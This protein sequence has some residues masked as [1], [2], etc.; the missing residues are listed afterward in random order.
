MRPHAERPGAAHRRTGSG[1]RQSAAHGHA[2]RGGH[3]RERQ[4]DDNRRPDHVRTRH[5]R[6][7]PACSWPPITAATLAI[8]G[9]LRP[10]QRHRSARRLSRPPA[11][12]AGRPFMLAVA[13]LVN[14]H[15]HC[16][17]GTSA[18]TGTPP[19]A[20]PGRRAPPD[21]SPT[22][23]FEHDFIGVY[24]N[25]STK[26]EGHHTTL[27][28]QLAVRHRPAHAARRT[29][30]SNTTSSDY[31]GRHGII[32]SDHVTAGSS[33]YNTTEGNGLNGI[34]MDE[35][36]TGN[37]IADNTVAGQQVRRRGDGQLQQQY[38]LR[39]TPYTATGSGSPCAAAPRDRRC[40]QHGD[41]QQN[42]RPGRGPGREHV[43]RQRRRSGRQAASA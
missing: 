4:L 31:N 5:D 14:D 33:A 42:G 38:A 2:E 36:S 34:M 43:L 8:A 37:I 29:W 12:V 30:S 16:T 32:F 28:P 25:D 6:H 3:H 13:G 11:Q 41:R 19:T 39:T 24:T 20:S 35:S 15:H 18:G 40:R 7:G 1:S 26:P 27:L 21:R 23:R 9:V 22:R 17:S 10:C